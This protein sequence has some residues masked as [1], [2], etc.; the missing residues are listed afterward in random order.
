MIKAIIFQNGN[1]D[2]EL[3]S[4][5]NLTEEEERKIMKILSNHETEGSSIRGSK[6]DIV[7]ET[8]YL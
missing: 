6:A 3:C 4:D 1:D 5:F 8:A 2:Y 7:E